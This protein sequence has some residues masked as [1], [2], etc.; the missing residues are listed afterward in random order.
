M[1][2]ALHNQRGDTIVEV[3]AA[4]VILLMVVAAF[5]NA[6]AFASRMQ[7][8]AGEIRD[9]T[10]AYTAALYDGIAPQAVDSK[11]YAF[12]FTSDGITVQSPS[13]AINGVQRQTVTVSTEFGSHTFRRFAEPVWPQGEEGD[14]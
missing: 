5:G 8:R 9:A 10:F 2:K 11:D 13:F 7:S 14:T 1:R 4:F 12:Y 6:I 3:L